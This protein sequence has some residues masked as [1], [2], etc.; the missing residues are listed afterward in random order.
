MIETIEI[1]VGLLAVVAALQLLAKRV[2]IPLPILLVI[3]G[4][5]LAFVPGLPRIQ[6]HPDVVLL[7]FLPPLVYEAAANTSWNDFRRNLSLITLLAFGLVLVSII[8]VA[9]V[10]HVVFPG[11]GWG[12]AFVL[13]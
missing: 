5:L 6:L 13:G 11:I 8:A 4:L 7:F 1:T 3:A 12:P 2:A 10:A 9:I